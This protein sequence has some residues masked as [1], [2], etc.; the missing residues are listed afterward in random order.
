M[1]CEDPTMYVIYIWITKT[2]Q[3]SSQT[4]LTGNHMTMTANPIS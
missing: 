2:G 3:H 1:H 4:K